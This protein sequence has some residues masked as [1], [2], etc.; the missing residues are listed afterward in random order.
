[1]QIAKEMLHKFCLGIAARDQLPNPRHPHGHERKFHSGE[2]S[3]ESNQHEY[4]D[5]A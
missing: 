1:M 2:E 5:E 3:V 4:P